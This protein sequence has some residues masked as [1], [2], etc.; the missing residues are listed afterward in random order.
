MSKA[1]PRLRTP[2]RWYGGKHYLCRRIVQVM[3]PHEV[4][5]EAY[6]G[7][8]AVLFAK[9]PSPVEVANDLNDQLV[10]FFRVVRDDA[11]RARLVALL[12]WTP[13]ARRE[14]EECLKPLPT[15]ADAVER[16]RRFFFLCRASFSGTYL[17]KR[18]P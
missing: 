11:L 7:S 1:T 3:P 8:G 18:H 9:E 17:G 2:I 5:V 16:A 14:F 12:D 15:D 6:F 4:Y 13:Y 10:N